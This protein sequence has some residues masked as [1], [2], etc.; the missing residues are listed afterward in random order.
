M[1]DSIWRGSRWGS[2]REH[3]SYQ[4]RI[5]ELEAQLAAVPRPGRKIALGMT[6]H[7]WQHEEILKQWIAIFWPA[8]G[9]GPFLQMRDLYVV[10]G[11]NRLT[12]GAL[13]LPGDTW[14]DFLFLDSDHFPNPYMVQRIREHDGRYPVL[15]GTYYGRGHPFDVQAWDQDPLISGLRHIDPA[16]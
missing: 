10:E 9:G 14:D 11:R 5:H 13:N 8:W 16:K 3:I 4:E 12:S 15:G 1:S 2:T 7:G 6:F